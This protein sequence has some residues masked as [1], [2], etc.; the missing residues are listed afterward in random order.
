MLDVRLRMLI[1]AVENSVSAASYRPGDI[2]TARNGITTLNVNSDAEGRLVLADCL[3][4][5]AEEEPALIIDCATLTGAQ[6]VALGP[7]IPG[8]FC[9]DD[10]IGD[11][12]C[13]VSKQVNDLVWRMP[14]HAPYKKMMETNIADIKSCASG[15][16]GGAIHA[17]LYLEEFVAGAPWVHMDLMGYNPASSP[18]RPEGGEAMG[19]RAL[20]HYLQGRFS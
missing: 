14:L 6:R 16:Y 9:N 8:M 10:D 20:F 11:E 5:A 18:G 4:A 12:L 13:R 15:P 2:L 3:A 17:A 1:P 7:E 19:M